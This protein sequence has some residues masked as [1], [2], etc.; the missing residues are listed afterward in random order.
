MFTYRL[1]IKVH[2]TANTDNERARALHVL[3]RLLGAGNVGKHDGYWPNYPLGK[4][5]DAIFSHWLNVNENCK[6]KRLLQYLVRLREALR[7]DALLVEVFAPGTQF[8]I[9]IEA[10]D[11][12][13][14]VYNEVNCLLNG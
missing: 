8:A 3:G 13:Q 2:V 14:S 9:G 10:G 5:T 1:R 4:E 11:C 6:I 12:W 7:Q